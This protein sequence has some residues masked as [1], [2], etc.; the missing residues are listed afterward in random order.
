MR[1]FAVLHKYLQSPGDL[2]K[3]AVPVDDA[4]QFVKGG[5]DRYKE[6]GAHCVW[7]GSGE[8]SHEQEDRGRAQACGGINDDA[9]DL[10]RIKPWQQ[11]NPKCREIRNQW[12]I[13]ELSGKSAIL[14]RAPGPGIRMLADEARHINVARFNGAAVWRDSGQ[15]HWEI[16]GDVEGGE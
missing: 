8:A 15:E 5:K 11:P 6:G 3:S 12:Q 16:Q 14:Q 9:I 7:A 1:A 2:F 13:D 10:C 4:D